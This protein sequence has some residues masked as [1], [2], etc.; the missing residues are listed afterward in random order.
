ME[1]SSD[2]NTRLGEKK[3]AFEYF[4]EIVGWVQIVASPFLA[5]L[6]I[7]AIIYFSKPNR[8]T[9]LIAIVIAI[10]GLTMG[11]VW[12]TRVWRKKGTMHF[13]SRVMATP[14]LDK[15]EDDQD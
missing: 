8:L 12:A 11:V 2:Q 15:K 10:I 7:G 4:T 1:D 3:S 5:G 13:M 14:E 6:I 9:L